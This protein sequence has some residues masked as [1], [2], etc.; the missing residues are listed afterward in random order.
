[1]LDFDKNDRAKL[2]QIIET[3][4]M[5]L[6]A[7]TIKSNAE[8]V[9]RRYDITVVYG[10]GI[11]K[12]DK[13]LLY[14]ETKSTFSVDLQREI[15]SMNDAPITGLIMLA[16]EA[17]GSTRA[18]MQSITPGDPFNGFLMALSWGLFP[19]EAENSSQRFLSSRN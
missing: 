15:E 9:P 8:D 13:K 2:R 1:M 17:A 5:D 12:G 14:C 6:L 11:I 4:P 3:H 7:I 18:Y 10:M 19:F 16:C